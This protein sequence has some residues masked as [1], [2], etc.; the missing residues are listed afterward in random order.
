MASGF[1]HIKVMNHRATILSNG[2]PWT[3]QQEYEKPVRWTEEGPTEEALREFAADERGETRA[4]RFYLA[5][6]LEKNQ[7][8]K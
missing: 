3:K 2:C 5:V 1:P 6:M 7:K 4:K 8:K